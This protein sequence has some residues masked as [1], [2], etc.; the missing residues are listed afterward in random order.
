[1]IKDAES[2]IEYH[3]GKASVK[4]PYGYKLNISNTQ[5]SIGIDLS[6]LGEFMNQIDY[7]LNPQN[8]TRQ[9]LYKTA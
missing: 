1:V 3:D 6:A 5:D 8:R 7:T 9:V 2:L 4:E